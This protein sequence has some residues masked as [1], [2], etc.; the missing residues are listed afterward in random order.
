MS[1]KN[2]I[3]R[4]GV[5]LAA[6]IGIA[7]FLRRPSLQ[8]RA[9]S[10]GQRFFIEKY[11]VTRG[12]QLADQVRLRCGQLMGERPLPEVPALRR[13]AVNNI[14]PGLALYQV[15]LQ[16]YEGDQPA[17][18][19]EVDQAFRLWTLNKSR[20]LLAPL[21]L[22]PSPFGLFRLVFGRMMRSFPAEGWDFH[23]GVFQMS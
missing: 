5:V 17:A 10:T 15:L 16:E 18:L 1:Y 7:V 8:E 14:L 23:L 22:V 13:H 20:P 11:G 6:G 12:R 3:I 19:A 21:R 9:F 4:V 2:K